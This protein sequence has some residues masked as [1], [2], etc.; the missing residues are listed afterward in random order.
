MGSLTV[1]S[2]KPRTAPANQDGNQRMFW[3]EMERLAMR[4]MDSPGSLT[5]AEISKM[6]RLAFVAMS[7][8]G[9]EQP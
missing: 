5:H 2:I 6:C 7:R 8:K 4:G 9:P 1:P 3:A